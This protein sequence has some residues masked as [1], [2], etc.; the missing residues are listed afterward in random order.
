MKRI[1]TIATLVALSG[2]A[3]F[4]S[5]ACIGPGSSGDVLNV[6][7]DL[8]IA[9]GTAVSG[10]STGSCTMEGFTFSNF[11]IF[12]NTGWTIPPQTVAPEI[13]LT[14]TIDN[15]AEGAIAIGYSNP[16][17]NASVGDFILTYTITPG[18]LAVGLNTGTAGAV[19]ENVCS[20]LGGVYGSFSGCGAGD[21]LTPGG[22]P[23]NTT[24]TYTIAASP[25]GFDIVTKDISGGSEVYQDVSPEPMTFSLMGGGLLGLGVLGRKLRK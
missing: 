15:G 11:A 9:N 17:G 24:G 6:A 14:F 10:V 21:S 2:V 19:S 5:D 25:S 4:A 12:G 3:A 13:D 20:A 22:T 7:I 8:S 18:I 16:T 23:I 1:L